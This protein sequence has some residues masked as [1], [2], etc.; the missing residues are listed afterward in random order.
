MNG[1]L[2][3]ILSVGVKAHFHIK[4]FKLICFIPFNDEVELPCKCIY[5]DFH[6]VKDMLPPLKSRFMYYRFSTPLAQLSMNISTS[7]L[8]FVK[9]IE[10]FSL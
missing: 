9:F 6:Q 8:I 2:V 4:S 1:I 3:P 10:K 5:F 7:Y